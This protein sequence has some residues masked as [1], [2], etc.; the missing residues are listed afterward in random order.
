MQKETESVLG[1][2][3]AFIEKRESVLFWIIFAITALVSIILFD[4][5]ISTGGDDAAYIIRANEFVKNFVFPTFQG[6]LY[7]I[8]LA[9]IVLIFGLSLVPLK[10]FSLVCMLGFIYMSYRTFKGKIPAILLFSGLLLIS[11]NSHVLYFASQTYNE[12]FF[13]FVQSVVFCFFVRFFIVEEE[14]ALKLVKLIKRHLWVAFIVLFAF[15]TRTIGFSLVIGICGYFLLYKRWKDL[16]LFIG[17]FLVLFI[18]Y[19]VV[20]SLIWSG[21]SFDATQLNGLLQKDY[22]RPELGN[23]D[24][25]GMFVRFWENSVI[26]LSGFVFNMLGLGVRYSKALT[27]LIYVI[28]IAALFLSYKKNKI[29]FFLGIISG[30]FLVSSFFILQSSWSQY[31]LIVPSFFYVVILLLAFFYYLFSVRLKVLQILIPVLTV[32]LF[33]AVIKDTSIAKKDMTNT[34]TP[35]WNNFLNASSWV[36]KNL[37]KNDKAASRKPDM[38]SIYANGK[39]FGGIYNVPAGDTD[40]FMD[41]WQQQ[42]DKF[43]AVLMT[44]DELHNYYKATMQIQDN[45]FRIIHN[46]DSISEILSRRKV[47]AIDFHQVKDA[48]E[49]GVH[50]SVFHADSL[51]NRFQRNGITHVMVASLRL[52][53]EVNDGQVISTVRR[54]LAFIV[55]K[56][57]FLFAAVHQEGTQEPTVVYKINWETIKK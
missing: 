53:P 26:Y 10:L 54:Y 28:S 3:D 5:K 9:P 31:R 13:M 40:L 52:N 47:Q 20:K 18:L 4:S 8:V 42:P 19:S 15:L 25:K 37:G 36:G 12:A 16:L 23:E 39:A 11:V 35:D 6:P 56:Y 44:D 38:S 46:T 29:I 33:F 43:M 17:S 2:V 7:P 32:L 14:Q 21:S 55:E 34:Y 27:I 50:L 41:E 30:T 57:P 22:Y 48:M 49:K 24:L 51:L 1:K 45:I